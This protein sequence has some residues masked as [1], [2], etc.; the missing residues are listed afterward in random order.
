MSEP[1]QGNYKDIKQ[2]QSQKKNKSTE[3]EQVKREGTLEICRGFLRV[4][5]RLKVT[6]KDHTWGNLLRGLHCFCWQSSIGL[7]GCCV[8]ILPFFWIRGALVSLQGRRRGRGAWCVCCQR[9]TEEWST[10]S[11]LCSKSNLYVQSFVWCLSTAAAW[12]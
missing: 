5:H 6:Y 4:C 11:N 9:T 12:L 1:Q 10:K 2:A 3:T 8:V 7:S